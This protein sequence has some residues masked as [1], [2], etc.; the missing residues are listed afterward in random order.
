M[1]NREERFRLT[2]SDTAI[3]L[4]L[5]AKV[6]GIESAEEYF[7][8]LPDSLKDKRIY[9]ALLNAYVHSRMAEKAESLMEK[10]RT[11]GYAIHALPFNVIMTLYMNLKQFDKVESVVSEM[12]EKKIRLDLYSYNIWLSC[13][14]S[15]GSAEKMEQV[16]EQMKLDTS[17]NP[18]WTTYSTLATLYIRLGQLEKAEECLK[19]IE[20]RITGRD[21][22][23]YHYLIS[24]YGSVGKK[25]EVLR[26]WD[27]YKSTFPTI[28]NLGYHALISSLIRLN[29]IEVAEKIYE[30]WISVKS[31]YDPRIGN[32]LLG[33]YVRQGSDKAAAFYDKMIEHGGKPNSTTWEILAESRIRERRI[34]EALSYL[35]DAFSTDGSKSWK[36]KPRNVTNILEICEE[37]GD[38][39]SKEALL[40]MLRQVGCLDNENYA[41]GGGETPTAKDRTEDDNNDSA[42][43]LLNQLQGSL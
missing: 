41:S 37:E 11:R 8:K 31:R 42:D 18:N 26:V 19:Q 15:Q 29:D 10:M 16:L 22:I 33:W 20:G 1:N 36:P 39:A 17:I 25:E 4:D 14:G 13:R 23:P 21:R 7:L 38:V 28:P 9:G 27:V 2:S 40:G 43:M 3:H 35:K 6:R 24:L 32:L 12:T 30:E 5:I 34:P